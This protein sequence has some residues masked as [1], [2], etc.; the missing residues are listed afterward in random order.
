MFKP[1]DERVRHYLQRVGEHFFLNESSGLYQPYPKPEPPPS[2]ST[3]DPLPHQVGSGR[4]TVFHVNVLRDWMVILIPAVFSLLTLVLLI[5]TVVYT[6]RQWLQANRS[7]N[8][9]ETAANAAQS[10][11]VTANN[12]LTEMK[13]GQGAQDTHKLADQAVKQATQTKSLAQTSKDAL[14]SVQRAFVFPS[15]NFTPIF[16]PNTTELMSVEVQPVW[17]NSGATPTKNMLLHGSELHMPFELPDNF[18]FPDLWDPGTAKI[19][20][21]SFIAPKGT[22]GAHPTSVP[23]GLIEEIADKKQNLYLWG[24][25]Q[26][27]DIFPH[28]KRHITRYCWKVSFPRVGEGSAQTFQFRTDNCLRNNC[29]DDECKVQ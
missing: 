15:T 11:A 4:Q 19:P 2:N 7:A 8:A 17:S 6:R 24:W 20:T 22:S 1:F 26:Y 18:N 28:T 21:P 14:I 10:A 5:A 23:L 25:A 3:P 27:N 16:K 13:T 9:S 12:T 29:S